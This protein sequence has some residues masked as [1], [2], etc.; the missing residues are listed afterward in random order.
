MLLGNRRRD[1]DP[2]LRA[3][4]YVLRHTFVAVSLIVS[5]RGIAL[6]LKYAGDP[7]LF[8]YLPIRYF[9]DAMDVAI[10]VAFGIAAVIA[11]VRCFGE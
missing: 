5:T 6:V 4:I 10:F 7:K 1:R 11:A 2:A 9:F 3:A 8:D